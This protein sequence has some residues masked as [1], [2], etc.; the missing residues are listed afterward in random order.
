MR[1]TRHYSPAYPTTG[2]FRQIIRAYLGMTAEAEAQIIGIA[3][4]VL[5]VLGAIIGTILAA[6]IIGV[7]SITITMS[8]NVAL[9]VEQKTMMG[10]QLEALDSRLERLERRL[11]A[12]ELK[13]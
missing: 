11:R 12:I 9:L 5:T 10:H 7:V 8:T 2:H 3:K 1:V 6:V 13:D 4:W